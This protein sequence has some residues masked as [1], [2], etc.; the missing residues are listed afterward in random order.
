LAF[1]AHKGLIYAC[2][3]TFHASK[4]LIQN[5]NL[6]WHWFCDVYGKI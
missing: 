1:L 6:F 3:H 4:R 5:K 2:F